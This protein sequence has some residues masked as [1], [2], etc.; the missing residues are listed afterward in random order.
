MTLPGRS[1]TK[2]APPPSSV[3]DTRA[4]A[5]QFGEAL[6]ERQADAH[7]APTGLVALAE[8]LEQHLLQLV[9]HTG[10]LVLHDQQHAVA[11]GDDVHEDRGPRRG[12]ARRVDEQV[13]DDALHLDRVDLHRHRIGLDADR[14]RAEPVPLAH[15][16]AHQLAH[17][18][19]QPL[20]SQLAAVDPVEVQEV[21]DETVHLAPALLD[22]LVQALALLVR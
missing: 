16:P 2:R 1:M 5:V 8:R 7:A 6:H 17:V 18:G 19:G 3:L 10:A 4:A 21:V 9:R 15:D 11:M 22:H 12:V 14:M 13:V 20:R